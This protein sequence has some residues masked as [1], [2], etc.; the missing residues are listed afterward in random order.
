MSDKEK[1]SRRSR[2]KREGDED[3]GEG[4][5]SSV[6]EPVRPRPKDSAGGAVMVVEEEDLGL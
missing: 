3:D 2:F 5:G 1:D 6:R 4:G